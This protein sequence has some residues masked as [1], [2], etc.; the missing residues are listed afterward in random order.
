MLFRSRW[1]S[2][3]R[4]LDAFRDEMLNDARVRTLVDF[5]DSRDCFPGVD[6]AGGICYFLWDRD[7]SGLCETTSVNGTNRLSVSRRLNEFPFFVR[8]ATSVEIIKKVLAKKETVMSSIVYSSKPFGFRSFEEGSSESFNDAVSLFGSKG[9][10]Y[11]KRELVNT[12]AD[13]IDK[14]KVVISKTS[15]EHAGQADKDGRKKVLSRI[16]ILEPDTICSESYL[17]LCTFD[18]KKNAENLK[19]YIQ[20][21]FF[22]FMMST[23]LLTQNI[24]KDKFCF[25]PF[26]DFT[27]EWTDEKLYEKYGLTADEIAFIESMIRPMQ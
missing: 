16:E 21:S 26:Q 2:G 3:G 11:V 15:A 27:Q 4:G 13:L 12:N 6:I 25:V 24:A 17:L 14:W 5:T 18:D 8:Y 1:F 19:L 20:S 22:R 7:N 9:I 10:S 23:V